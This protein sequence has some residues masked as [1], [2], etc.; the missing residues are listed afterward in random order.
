MDGLTIKRNSDLQDTW[1]IDV[2]DLAF[3]ML[4]MC[5]CKT[6]QWQT[7]G[8][9]VQELNACTVHTCIHTYIDPI[10]AGVQVG[11]YIST[12]LA[13]YEPFAYLRRL[14]KLSKAIGSLV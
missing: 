2:L 11:Y 9:L 14:F 13:K 6:R 3:H 12:S 5:V 8:R 7:Y 10:D 4:S 1:V